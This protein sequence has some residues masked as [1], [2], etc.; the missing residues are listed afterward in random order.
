MDK[1]TKTQ[2]NI[3]NLVRSVK[4]RVRCTE[5]KG[6]SP[7]IC[8]N[9]LYGIATAAYFAVPPSKLCMYYFSS[10]ATTARVGVVVQLTLF[11]LIFRTA[12]HLIHFNFITTSI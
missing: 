3:A 11:I 8:P 10:T 7:E 4:E 6:L 9:W 12:T 2:E 5:G 1:V